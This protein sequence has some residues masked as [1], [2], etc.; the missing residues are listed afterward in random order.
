[1]CRTRFWF[2]CSSTRPEAIQIL[3]TRPPRTRRHDYDDL[4]Y[5]CSYSCSHTCS[6]THSDG[7]SCSPPGTRPRKRKHDKDR[8]LSVRKS[9]RARPRPPP[10]GADIRVRLTHH[11]TSTPNTFGSR[12]FNFFLPPSER[13]CEPQLCGAPSP[14]RIHPTRTNHCSR[15]RPRPRATTGPTPKPNGK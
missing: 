10:T 4:R 3:E 11:T 6:Y 15:A 12:E 14:E 9:C 1:M 8:P 5:S 2:L 7:P 13:I